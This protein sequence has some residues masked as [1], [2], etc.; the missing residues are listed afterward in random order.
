[1]VRYKSRWIIVK[2][3][4]DKD[5]PPISADETTYNPT[6]DD[7]RNVISPKDISIALRDIVLS[8]FGIAGIGVIEGF[9]G[10]FC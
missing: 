7:E 4:F 2:I 10:T 5:L 1:M 6:I 8:A 3:E 9:Q